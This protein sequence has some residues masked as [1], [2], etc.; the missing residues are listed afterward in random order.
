MQLSKRLLTVANMVTSAR[1]LADVGTDHGYIPIY[2][3]EEGRAAASIAMDV[4]QGPLKRAEA[5]IESHGLSSKI[6]TRLSDGVQALKEG[7]ADS[8]VIAGMGGGLVQKILRE[9]SGVLK[10]VE[11]LILQ[12]QSELEEVR[13]FLYANGYEIEDEEMV[14]EDGKYYP[15]MKAV[16][17]RQA[18]ALTDLEYKYGPVLLRKKHECLLKY[19][20]WEQAV[21]NNVL[22]GLAGRDGGAARA[23]KC[24]IEEKLACLA[25]AK[26][27]YYEMR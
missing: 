14:L 22:E 17:A 24:E 16:H 1:C 11:Y 15:M 18:G 21:L 20:E 4:N 3:V 23:R 27:C 25:R 7:E 13:R 8:V 9:G 19:L 2:L 5:N 26:E 12:P 10:G 6:Q